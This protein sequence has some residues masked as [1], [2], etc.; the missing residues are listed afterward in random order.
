MSSIPAEALGHVVAGQLDVHP[1]RPGPDLAV[2]TEE[3]AELADDVVEA[4]RL[5]TA[6][7]GEGVAVHR[8]A[9]PH[10]R[11]ALVADRREQRRERVL[12]RVDAEAGDQREAPGDP[13]RD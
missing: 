7:G 6:V 10:D 9:D 8:V 4:P 12:D 13:C 2:G 1:A 3:A 11:V 5:V